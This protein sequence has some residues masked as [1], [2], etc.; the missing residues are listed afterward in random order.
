MEWPTSFLISYDKEL[1]KWA[2]IADADDALRG[3]W[4]VQNQNDDVILDYVS[5]KYVFM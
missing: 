4:G 1:K 5:N 2:S 3:G